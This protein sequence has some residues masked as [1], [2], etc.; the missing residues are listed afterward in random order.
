MNNL[1]GVSQLRRRPE[2]GAQNIVTRN[3]L[4]PRF[5]ESLDFQPFDSD[6]SLVYV[7][8]RFATLTAVEQHALL[9]R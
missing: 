8:P 6:R 1:Q 7:K 4:I 5:N 9:H 3:H 2:S